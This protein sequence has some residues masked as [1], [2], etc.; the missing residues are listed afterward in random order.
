[1]FELCLIEGLLSF[2]RLFIPCHYNAVKCTYFAMKTIAEE[3]SDGS[4][5]HF[6]G[7]SFLNESDDKY[8]F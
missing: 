4:S 6:F 5:K 2:L 1:M 7:I 8:A 3:G